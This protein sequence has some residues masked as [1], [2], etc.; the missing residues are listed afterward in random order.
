[1]RFTGQV[2][3]VTGAGSGIGAAVARGFAAQGGRVALA[4]LD[5]GRA[6]AVARD[7]G[8]ALALGCDVADAASVDEA[9]A[10]AAA[11]F[12]RIDAVLNSAGHVVLGT[13]EETAPE[14]WARLL[15]VHVNGTYNV[16]RATLPHLRAA[17]GGAIVNMASIAAL[18]GRPRNA[19]YAAAKGA[20]LALSRQMAIDLAP[21]GIRVNSV[22]PGPVRT[23][24]TEG[25]AA[26]RGMDWATGSQAMAA[27]IPMG[28]VGTADE[29]A[30]PV[31]FLL[32]RDAA[33][34]TGTNIV[35]DGGLTAS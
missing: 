18:V 30:A 23:A 2:L 11:H 15:A 28:R 29:A 7:L 25:F 5:A 3:F 26:A 10:R 12:G 8:D 21:E 14:D 1:M 6:D 19:A 22:A 33:Y 24:M 16:C 20:I 9:V 17:G 35:P 27:G 31:L 4:D 13:I 34:L 32:S